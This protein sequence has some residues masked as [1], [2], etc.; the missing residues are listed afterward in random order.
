M[1]YLA[2]ALSGIIL[3]SSCSGEV[4]LSIYNNTNDI[5]QISIISNEFSFRLDTIQDVYSGKYFIQ[6]KVHSPHKFVMRNCKIDTIKSSI[7][8]ISK[9]VTAIEER[10][11]CYTSFNETG[12]T[13]E[14]TFTIPPEVGVEI[15]YERYID[16]KGSSLSSVDTIY[17]QNNETNIQLNGVDAIK[18]NIKNAKRCSNCKIIIGELSQ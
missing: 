17:F 4:Q 9:I 3:V 13:Q 11:F 18:S 7:P 15:F 12:T 2:L 5:V 8:P 6:Q 14:L 16:L 1:K 10:E